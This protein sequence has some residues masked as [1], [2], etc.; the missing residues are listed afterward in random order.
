MWRQKAADFTELLKCLT[1]P[2]HR[3]TRRKSVSSSY[4]V[5]KGGGDA[6]TEKTDFNFFSSPDVVANSN[7]TSPGYFSALAEPSAA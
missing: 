1:A 3:K 5:L 4:F 2:F 7:D 6:I